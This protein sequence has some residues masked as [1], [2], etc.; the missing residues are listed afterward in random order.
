MDPQLNPNLSGEKSVRS[1][2][3]KTKIN[4]YYNKD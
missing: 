3:M 2:A 4:P 1:H